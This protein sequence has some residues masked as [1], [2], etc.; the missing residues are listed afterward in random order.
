MNNFAYELSSAIEPMQIASHL[1]DTGAVPTE[2]NA[3]I[4]H[5]TLIT[6]WS[7]DWLLQ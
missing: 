7:G 6:L 3:Y 5:N 1:Q 2:L 4:S